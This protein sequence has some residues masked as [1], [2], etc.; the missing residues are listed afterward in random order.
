MSSPKF[1]PSLPQGA[2]KSEVEICHNVKITTYANGKVD[3]VSCG[4]SIF[5]EPGW[6][7]EERPR[8]G[9]PSEEPRKRTSVRNAE[10]GPKDVTRS[11]RRAKARVREIALANDFQYFV[12][13]TLDPA[14]VDR[15]DVKTVVKKLSQWADNQA[16]RHGLRY[17]LVPERHKDGAIHFHGFMSWPENPPVVPSGTY[18]KPGWKKPR[19]ARSDAQAALWISQ[20]AKP[21]YN[22]PAWTLGFTTAIEVYGEYGAAV[23]YVCKYVGKQMETGKIGGRWYY[24]GGPLIQPEVRYADLDSGIV[25]NLP[26]AFEVSVP[27]VGCIQLWRGTVDELAAL[28]SP[29]LEAL[30]E[31]EVQR[32]LYTDYYTPE[33]EDAWKVEFLSE[34]E[35]E[36]RERER[37]FQEMVREGWRT[38]LEKRVNGELYAEKYRVSRETYYYRREMERKKYEHDRSRD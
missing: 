9:R 13:L 38:F 22:L 15:Y 4:K 2:S 7:V 5:R 20:G 8:R 24:S 16:R 35:W 33:P 21:V 11:V 29:R 31:Y 1:L 30:A 17:V 23:N 14:K 3:V 36:A 34:E 19:K 12:T 27:G 10:D 32:D 26:G 25:A 6:E 37:V 28:L 18:T